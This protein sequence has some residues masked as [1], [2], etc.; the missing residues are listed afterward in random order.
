MNA[1]NVSQQIISRIRMGNAPYWGVGTEYNQKLSEMFSRGKFVNI[2]R[3]MVLEIKKEY[4]NTNGDILM[5]DLA[6]RLKTS[7]G[8]VSAILSLRKYKDVA[9]SYN[10]RILSIKIG[11]I[12]SL[13]KKIS[14]ENKRNE[15][16]LQKI[17]QLSAKVETNK[18]R[19]I[20][21]KS[22]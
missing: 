15:D 9:S 20:A 2:D 11:K 21:L 14:S 22:L 5:I 18:E 4:V 12:E 17:S 19:I 8:T 13:N 7:I 6:K 3:R 10:S 1:F 16:L